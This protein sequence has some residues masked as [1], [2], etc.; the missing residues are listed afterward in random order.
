MLTLAIP[1][2]ASSLDALYLLRALMGAGE[3]VTYPAANVLYTQ[4]MPSAER[5]GLVAFSNAGSYL[6]TALAF[7]TAKPLEPPVR[8]ARWP[9][10]AMA[11]A[12]R[13]FLRPPPG[14]TTLLVAVSHVLKKIYRI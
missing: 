3:A 6:G 7:P 4:W 9:E 11:G 8:C 14:R 12:R 2:C 1:L 5:A 10:T 13:A